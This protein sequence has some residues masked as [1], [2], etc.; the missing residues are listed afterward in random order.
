MRGTCSEHDRNM[1]GTYLNHVRNILGTRVRH[2]RNILGIFPKPFHKN[3]EKYEISYCCK[4]VIPE[5]KILNLHIFNSLCRY[6]RSSPVI[7]TP[8]TVVQ[9]NLPQLN[10]IPNIP[11]YYFTKFG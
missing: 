8:I 10:N 4:L 2:A 11:L 9:L 5:D 1:L 3:Y 7:E 6:T